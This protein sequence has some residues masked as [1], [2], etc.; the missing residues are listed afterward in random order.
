MWNFPFIIVS[1][2]DLGCCRDCVR[3]TQSHR[4]VASLRR[5][6][7]N[8]SNLKLT[9]E[10]CVVVGGHGGTREDTKGRGRGYHGNVPGESSD[11]D[12][13]WFSESKML[14]R[15]RLCNIYPALV[16]ALHRVRR[17]FSIFVKKKRR[18]DPF[19]DETEQVSARNQLLYLWQN[20][21]FSSTRDWERPWFSHAAHPLFARKRITGLTNPGK[22]KSHDQNTLTG[23]LSAE[24]NNP[25]RICLL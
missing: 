21:A 1:G 5:Q 17:H 22:S 3:L 14:Q 19:A 4:R 24:R 8:E 18:I 16:L 2:V 20:A 11:G 10:K 15:P 25:Q 7:E 13:T 12:S 6:Q 23:S 9:K